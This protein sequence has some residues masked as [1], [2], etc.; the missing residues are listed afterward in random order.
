LF[1]GKLPGGNA[2]P[3]NGA[4]TQAAIEW[5]MNFTWLRSASPIITP[6]TWA[7]LCDIVCAYLKP[8]FSDRKKL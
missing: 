1:T 8:D 3:P 6:M 4:D 2:D 7:V 5:A